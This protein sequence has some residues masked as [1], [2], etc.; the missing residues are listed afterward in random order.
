MMASG[1]EVP[2]ARAVKR[3][4]MA[5]TLL[6][7]RYPCHSGKVRKCAGVGGTER[8]KR[9]EPRHTKRVHER[10]GHQRKP[11]PFSLD[12]HADSR[13][14]SS[15]LW[16]RS[17]GA[18]ID[19]L[20]AHATDPVRSVMTTRLQPWLI[21]RDASALATPGRRA[22]WGCASP[23]H[24]PCVTDAGLATLRG[25]THL[26]IIDLSETGISA[27][28]VRDLRRALKATRSS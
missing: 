26:R 16:R 22:S 3:A 24:R 8:A 18:R 13:V 1:L 25:M 20:S 28:G 6:T 27:V 11:Q 14:A 4:I 23:G 19:I 5:L 12:R 10:E 17:R 7:G 15:P 2:G 21:L 9:G